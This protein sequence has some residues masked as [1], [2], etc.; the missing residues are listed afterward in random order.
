[1]AKSEKKTKENKKDKPKIPPVK[2]PAPI[3][4]IKELGFDY[5]FEY[6]K[7]KGTDDKKWL[8]ELASSKIVIKDE[9]E[10]IVKDEN[11]NDKERD[12]TFL[13]IRNEF[14]K[15][16]MS[17]IVPKSKPKKPTM[18]KMLESL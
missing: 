2:Y 8:K 15:K 7:A 4:D 3:S 18:K 11:G 6:I 14:A 12:I 5:I 17:E 16:Y 13:E 9:N 1:M 10:K